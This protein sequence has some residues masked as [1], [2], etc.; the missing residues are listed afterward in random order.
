M[1][2]LAVY[3][4]WHPGLV[5]FLIRLLIANRGGGTSSCVTSCVCIPVQ[6]AFQVK[7]VMQTEITCRSVCIHGLCASTDTYRTK[8]TVN[9]IPQRLRNSSL[10]TPH[11]LTDLYFLSLKRLKSSFASLP[12]L[13]VVSV[14]FIFFLG[15]LT[16]DADAQSKWKA[17]ESAWQRNV[18]EKTKRMSDWTDVGERVGRWERRE[19][20][21]EE[22]EDIFRA[23]PNQ[24][25]RRFVSVGVNERERGRE[26]DIHKFNSKNQYAAH[27]LAESRGQRGRKN[28]EQSRK[29]NGWLD[30]AE[31]ERFSS[32]AAAQVL[33]PQINLANS[34]V[35]LIMEVW[36]KRLKKRNYFIH[37]GLRLWFCWNNRRIKI[38]PQGRSPRTPNF[39]PGLLF[40]FPDLT[41]E[42]ALDVFFVS[43]FD[44][45]GKKNLVIIYFQ[46]SSNELIVI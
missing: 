33:K 31:T 35:W 45:Q 23:A 2:Q 37:W 3:P 16:N 24:L 44:R 20:E 38:I 36:I 5:S 6:S 17:G 27:S 25:L 34:Y 42:V 14:C 4:W 29:T 7:W 30:E 19:E 13:A 1:G 18:R 43:Q 28:G 12:N 8:Q 39:N 11:K 26:R 40:R 21:E 15:G 22:V 46:Q 41:S 10:L 32:N 9:F